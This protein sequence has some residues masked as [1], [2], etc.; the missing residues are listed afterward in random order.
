MLLGKEICLQISKKVQDLVPNIC[1]FLAGFPKML[2]EL[3]HHKEEERRFVRL[4]MHFFLPRQTWRNM[5]S[6]ADN[7]GE[8]GMR[9][10]SFAPSM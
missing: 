5:Q 1:L 9:A 7:S 4:L 3:E 6:V 2:F 8:R 10:A